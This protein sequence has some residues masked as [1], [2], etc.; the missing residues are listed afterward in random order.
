M[1]SKRVERRHQRA[2]C[3]PKSK[4]EIVNK[5]IVNEESDE[6]TTNVSKRETPRDETRVAV[7]YK[8]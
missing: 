2:K 7:K 1:R 6:S 3:K 5:A 8:T 4:R